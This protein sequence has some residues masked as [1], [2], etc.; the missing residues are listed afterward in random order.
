[1]EGR[2]LTIVWNEIQTPSISSKVWIRIDG[3]FLDDQKLK[4]LF[5][6]YGFVSHC[7]FSRHSGKT[8]GAVSFQLDGAADSAVHDLNGTTLYGRKL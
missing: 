3:P 4:V 5:S 1:M 8:I 6:L 7:E 2:E